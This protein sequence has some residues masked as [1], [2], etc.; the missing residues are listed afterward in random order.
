MSTIQITFSGKS[1]NA[2]SLTKNLRGEVI[3]TLLSRLVLLFRSEEQ[4]QNSQKQNHKNKYEQHNE[5]T[6]LPPVA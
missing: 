2:P 6:S 5:H 3:P 4:I 1:A